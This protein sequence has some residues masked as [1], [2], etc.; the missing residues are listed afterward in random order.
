[1]SVDLPTVAVTGGSGFV[2]GH[3][4][5]AATEAGWRIRL[6]SRNRPARMNLAGCEWKKFDLA[7]DD[8]FPQDFFKGCDAVV[9]LAAYIPRNMSDVHEADRCWRLNALATIRLLEATK[10]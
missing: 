1:M 5:R 3:F 7:A 2:G 4:V 9:H 10:S 6:L 8:A